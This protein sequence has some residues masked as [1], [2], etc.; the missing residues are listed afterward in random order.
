[1][2]ISIEALPETRSCATGVKPETM[3]VAVKS[4]FRLAPEKITIGGIR[5]ENPAF[6]F[7]AGKAKAG[8]KLPRGKYFRTHEIIRAFRIL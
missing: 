3:E 1:M 2:T 5:S 6:C 8:E 4:A 7:W